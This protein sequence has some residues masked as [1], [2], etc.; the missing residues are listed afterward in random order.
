MIGKDENRIIKILCLVISLL[1]HIT[2]IY[3]LGILKLPEPFSS[4]IKRLQN[5]K[6]KVVYV[7][8]LDIPK[9]K[10][11]ETPKEKN[12]PIISQFTTRKKG[13]LGKQEKSMLSGE[14]P[15]LEPKPGLPFKVTASAPAESKNMKSTKSPTA[16]KAEGKKEKNLLKEE[17]AKKK[18]VK[19]FKT[20]TQ[21]KN[22]KTPK[23]QKENEK[24]ALKT[25][26]VKLKPLPPL[27]KRKIPLIDPRLVSKESK[28]I[29]PQMGEGESVEISLDTTESKYI[30]YFKHIRDKL[31]L[32]W[33]YPPEA[34][35][36]GI[37][38][39][40][41]ILFIIERDGKLKDVRIL[42]TSGYPILDKEAVR[43]IIAASPFGPF[44][45][46]WTEKEL[47]IRARFTYH[48]FSRSP[49]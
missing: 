1:I 11:R 47:R 44:P 5:R 35:A 15:V 16:Q 4:L 22:K 49:F 45:P 7:K 20:E 21:K 18:L 39:T 19:K 36:A 32:V 17:K 23:K 14:S 24:L 25:P 37:Q 31:Y 30:S 6:E 38:G 26:S 13:P 42:E 34:A 8:I 10:K 29:V 33:R 43:A 46:D 3:S 9:P 41:K 28:K 48:L 27:P 2:V 40:V 12:P